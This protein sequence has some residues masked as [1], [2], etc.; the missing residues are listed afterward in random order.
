[1]SARRRSAPTRQSVRIERDGDGTVVTVA[2]MKQ[3]KV[4]A[5]LRRP[6]E[7]PDGA[8]EITELRFY[9]DN[10][11]AFVARARQHLPAGERL[12]TSR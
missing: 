3:T 6:L 1:M 12:A 9:V 11:G 8:E 10:P 2:V 4:E 5:V 7:L